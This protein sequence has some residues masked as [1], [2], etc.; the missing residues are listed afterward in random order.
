M[1]THIRKIAITGLVAVAALG[2]ATTYADTLSDPST[3]LGLFQVNGELRKNFGTTR[4]DVN[5]GRVRIWDTNTLD[6]FMF[7]TN[8]FQFVR[9]GATYFDNNTA[10]ASIRFRLSTVANA[11][12]VNSLILDSN[13]DATLPAGDVV[14]QNGNVN[15]NGSGANGNLTVNGTGSVAILEIRGGSDLAEAFDVS[16]AASTEVIPGMVVSIDPANAGKL[17]VSTE[18]YD[19]K[20]AGIISGAGGLNT[21]MHMGQVGTIA[22]GDQMV[23]LTGRVYCYV[24]GAFGAIQPGDLLTTSST[25]GHAMRVADTASAQGAIIGKAMTPLAAGEKGLVLVLVNLH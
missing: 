22:H 4:F 13:G 12:N 6:Y 2:T 17:M 20:V 25:P 21:G 5:S 15:I 19:R 8:G 3:A 9:P 11:R 23:A 24:D 10:N 1:F 18:A 16:A 14:L 7:T